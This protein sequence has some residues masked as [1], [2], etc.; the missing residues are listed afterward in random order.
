M[1]T[2]S[3]PANDGQHPC[4]STDALQAGQIRDETAG[5]RD[6]A[7][8]KRDELAA[9]RDREADIADRVLEQEDD[10]RTHVANRATRFGSCMLAPSRITGAQRGTG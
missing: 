4:S 2:T 3:G 5:E 1:L 8:R 9:G 6:R 10:D 7:A